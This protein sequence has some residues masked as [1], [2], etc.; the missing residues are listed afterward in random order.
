MSIVYSSDTKPC[1]NVKN[2]SKN[3][4]VLIHDA[5]YSTQDG[6]LS[7]ARFHTTIREACEI[8]EISNV[9]NLFLT[10]IS[11]RYKD[12]EILLEE[13]KKYFKKSFIANDLDKYRINISK[14]TN[15][16]ELEKR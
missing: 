3:A 11:S 1:E 7:E 2:L 13:A 5:T 14:T 12:S 4:F 8:A 16:L 15:E 10:H 9:K 6:E